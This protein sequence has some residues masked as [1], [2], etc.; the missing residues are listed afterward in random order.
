MQ[1]LYMIET[2][3][4]G[5]FHLS[6]R[7]SQTSISENRILFLVRFVLSNQSIHLILYIVMMD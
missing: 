3:T 2:M 1:G 6:E 5:I 4:K 7:T